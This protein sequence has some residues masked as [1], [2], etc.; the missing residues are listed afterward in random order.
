MALI[1]P[2]VGRA[3]PIPKA[4]PTKNKSYLAWIHCLPCIITGQYGVEAA[5]LSMSAP[6]YGHY[7]RARGHKAP[8]RWIL[9][10]CK[11]AHDRSHA[12]G[13]D[14]FWRNAG[15]DPHI[16]A[17]VIYGL[18]TDLGDDAE[19]FATAIITAARLQP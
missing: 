16:L 15:I 9:P 6:R 11:A 12:I 1:A 7:G 18:W 17:L 8:D 13:E 3:S 14:L 5:H 4:K 19:P 2:H 10:L